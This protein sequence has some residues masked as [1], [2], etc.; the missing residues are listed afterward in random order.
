MQANNQ[1]IQ[2]WF[3]QVRR[4]SLALPRFQRFEAWSLNN[5]TTLLN[6]IL[7]GL[8]VGSLLV[9]RSPEPHAFV[10]RQLAGVEHDIGDNP[11]YL[12]DGQQRLTALWRAL[13]NNYENHR[14]FLRLQPSDEFNL[15][16]FIDSKPLYFKEK[17]KK[18]YPEWVQSRTELWKNRC[19]PLEVFCPG[20]KGQEEFSKWLED[21]DAS[22]DDFILLSK[23]TTIFASYNLP[24]LALSESTPKEVALDVFIKMNTTA[25]PLTTYDIVVAQV[26]AQI[27]QSLHDLVGDIRES[28]PEVE[29]YA[30]PEDLVLNASAFLQD[31]QPNNTT[32]LQKGFAEQMIENWDDLVKGIRRAIA[33]LE[34]ERIYDSK[35]LPSEVVLPVICSIWAQSPEYGDEEGRARTLLRKYIWRA[36]F[37]DRYE[38]TTQSRALTDYRQIKAAID[39]KDTPIDIFNEEEHPLPQVEE[40]LMAGW[41]V[42]KDRLARAILATSL[43]AGGLDLADGSTVT[44]EN[45]L[46]REY[47]HLFPNAR[48]KREGRSEREIFRSLN[49]ALVTWKTNRKI[50]DKE[51]EKYL[52]ERRDGTDLGEDEVRHRLK[53]HLIPYEEMTAGNYDAFLAKRAE[54]IHSTMTSL[55]NGK[56]G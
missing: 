43:R 28:T 23:L 20:T 38:R 14:F 21:C 37:T 24:Y 3:S 51:P 49:N 31:R 22:R 40:L 6:T 44:R 1:Q 47:H 12:L 53:T 55:C 41:P 15:P 50:S 29:S 35:R 9:Y 2:E 26:E 32:F 52:T 18:W 36:F 5:V 10:C 45:V 16:Y 27:D 54:M 33:F 46:K 25:A 7:R 30:K 34:E 19:V 8:P 11:E 42:R 56:A 13:H 17:T 4:G 39:G 48:L